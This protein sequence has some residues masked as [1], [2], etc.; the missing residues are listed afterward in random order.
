[1]I[2]LTQIETDIKRSSWWQ[3]AAVTI[4][5]RHSNKSGVMLTH[6]LESVYQNVE[7]I[8]QQPA[9]GFYGKLIALLP[10][11]KLDKEALKNELKIVALL[12]DIGKYAYHKESWPQRIKHYL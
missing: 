2:N 12:N 4:D 1:M 5:N 11:L 9:T 6:H 8:F 7:A 10:I 3:K